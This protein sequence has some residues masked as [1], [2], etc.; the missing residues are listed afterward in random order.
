MIKFITSRLCFV[1]FHCVMILINYNFN[2]YLNIKWCRVPKKI[3]FFVMKLNWDAHELKDKSLKLW[4]CNNDS[5][6][7]LPTKLLKYV[8][9][10][11]ICTGFFTRRN[12]G[13]IYIYIYGCMYVYISSSPLSLSLSGKRR[14]ARTAGSGESSLLNCRFTS[15]LPMAAID[16]NS[17][18]AS[19]SGSTRIVVERNPSESKLSQLNIQCWPK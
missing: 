7:L 9:I 11:I 6:S 12:L 16:A 18:P 14:K 13:Y 19:S 8:D 4:R 15:R 2:K 17:N 1:K 5:P 10:Y 3:S